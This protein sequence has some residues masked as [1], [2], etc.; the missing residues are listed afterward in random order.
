MFSPNIDMRRIL[1]ATVS[2]ALLLAFYLVFVRPPQDPRIEAILEKEKLWSSIQFLDTAS[3]ETYVD[4]LTSR[5]ASG[6]QAHPYLTGTQ[7]ALLGPAIASWIDAYS[8]KDFERFRSFRMA[9]P[10][11]IDL[12]KSQRLIASYEAMGRAKFSSDP[13]RVLQELYDARTTL[14]IGGVAPDTL[15]IR[16]DRTSATNGALPRLCFDYYPRELTDISNV[17]PF[18]YEDS[19]QRARQRE[20]FL[21][22]GVSVVCKGTEPNEVYPLHV[23]LYWSEK[24][25]RWLPWE[26]GLGYLSNLASTNQLDRMLFF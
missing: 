11:S 16:V 9:V 18:L 8:G 12:T 21:V 20:T 5:A 17:S 24:S 7:A 1:I 19:P 22:C 4:Q 15:R 26:M 25:M 10:T 14:K 6:V 13:D 23:V 2:L 3:I